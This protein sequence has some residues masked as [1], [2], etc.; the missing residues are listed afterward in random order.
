MRPRLF[1][2]AV[3]V[4]WTLTLC[5]GV[6]ADIQNPGRS[7]FPGERSVNR[8]GERPPNAVAVTAEVV[9]G[10]TV[11][12][13]L[14]A[15]GHAGEMVDF[16]IRTPPEHGTLAGPPRQ[17]TLNT[18]SV[19]YLPRPGD[20]SL[21]DSFTYAVQTRDSP[22]SAEE[23]VTIRIQDAPPVLA[24]VP[25]ELD[26]GAVKAGESTRAEVTLTNQGGGEAVGRLDP[27]AP[28]VVDGPAT[29]HL[30]RGASQT[31]ALVFQPTGEHAYAD[32]LHFRYE[33][34]GGVRLVGTGLGGPRPP[35]AIGGTDPTLAGHPVL[36][37][38][39]PGVNDDAASLPP[40]VADPSRT[41]R[42][43]P[44]APVPVASPRAASLEPS[45][46]GNG[47]PSMPSALDPAGTDYND[48]GVS[49]FSVRARGRTTVDL[50]WRALT[51]PPKSYR[52][53][54]RYLSLDRDDRLIVEWRPYARVDFET[55]HGFVNARLSGLT[56]ASEVCVRIVAVDASG[57]LAT[58][59]PLRVMYTLPPSTW[60][61]PT[62][63]KVLCALLLLCGGL[64]VR[65]RWEVHQIL[66]EI[67][68]SRRQAV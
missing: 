26:F 54:L 7:S 45:I 4:L 50:S 29:Y 9:Q 13:T 1:R 37:H 30:V 53:E 42:H 36:P 28:W 10:N 67:D 12:I 5:G 8:Q 55:A 40:T 49:G 33:I 15:R 24:I 35:S 51:P 48:N 11:T 39:V 3:L 31:F 62:P 43:D 59:S 22:V 57:R 52:V 58:P 16:L 64:A 18:A 14:R 47:A 41:E 20:D 68:D 2:R 25:A 23:R 21:A 27:P 66:R 56:P 38:A 61:Q 6:R 32:A 19:V 63:L 17:L 44:G 46:Q 34:G 60:W 65:H